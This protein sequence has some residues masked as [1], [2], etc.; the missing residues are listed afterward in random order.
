[1]TEWL[2]PPHE[3]DPG[4]RLV[5]REGDSG[6]CI[7]LTKPAP[8]EEAGMVEFAVQDLSTKDLLELL[9]SVIG[10][11]LDDCPPEV[12]FAFLKAMIAALLPED[13]EA[14]S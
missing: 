11:V 6:I 8:G 12:R 9:G 7:R 1:V 14:A 3:P 10:T 4:Q 2:D 13:E 5:L